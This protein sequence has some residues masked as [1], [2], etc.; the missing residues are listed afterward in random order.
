MCVVLDTR[1]VELGHRSPEGFAATG[2]ADG[3][4]RP[5]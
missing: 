2:Q 4:G 1:G 5:I 3:I